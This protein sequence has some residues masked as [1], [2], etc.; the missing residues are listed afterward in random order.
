MTS[1]RFRIAITVHLCRWNSLLR[2]L[3][4]RFERLKDEGYVVLLSQDVVWD[5][6]KLF[7]DPEQ[8]RKE[9]VAAPAGSGSMSPGMREHSSNGAGIHRTFSIE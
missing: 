9:K 6:H 2:R 5:T 4:S 1:R 8:H 7:V 3:W